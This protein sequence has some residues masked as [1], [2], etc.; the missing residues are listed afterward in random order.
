MSQN[1]NR[2]NHLSKTEI[3]LLLK[4]CLTGAI[5]KETAAERI[6]AYMQDYPIQ[7]LQ[8]LECIN[9]IG[10]GIAGCFLKL[11]PVYQFFPPHVL[12]IINRCEDCT[13]SEESCLKIIH[14]NINGLRTKLEKIKDIVQKFE[15][16]G[17]ICVTETNNPKKADVKID[18]YKTLFLKNNLNEQGRSH[19]GVAMYVKNGLEATSMEV[20]KE[21]AEKFKKACSETIWTK[22]IN[23]GS[24]IF[25]GVI[26]RHPNGNREDFQN[27]LK[28]ALEELAQNEEIVYVFGDFNLDLLKHNYVLIDYCK[29]LNDMSFKQLVTTATRDTGTLLDHIY[30]NDNS[31]IDSRATAVRVKTASD[32]YLVHCCISL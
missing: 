13:P 25:V 5:S 3:E 20:S 31:R 12:P 23:N 7:K 26:Y 22:I 27:A 32:H 21:T 4:D 19:G 14:V 11:F 9:G 10:R 18:G 15:K 30:T 6:F 17:L 29:M 24:S 8:D 2:I 28:L 1:E 16:P